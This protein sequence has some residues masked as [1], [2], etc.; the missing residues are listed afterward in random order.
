MNVKQ[1]LIYTLSGSLALILSTNTSA[2]SF[3]I[4]EQSPAYLG[5]AF[6]G[7]A[8]YVSDASSIFFN[9]AAIGELE[10]SHLTVAGN[11]IFTRAKFN[12]QNSNTNGAPGKTDE[13]G[14]VPNLYWTYPVAERLTFG[15]GVNAP[16]GLSSKYRDDWAGRYLATYSN[17]ELINVNAVAALDLGD[18]W[19]L[20][21]GLNYQRLDVTLESRVDSTLGI[22]PQPATDSSARIKGDDDDLVADLSLYFKPSS[23]TRLG[24]VWR[25]GGEFDL[26]GDA[27]F[28]LNALCSPGAG[29]PTGVPPAPTTGT[30]CAAMLNARAGDAKTSIA[31]PDTLTFSISQALSERWWLHV[32]VARTEWSSLQSVNIINTGNNLTISELELKYKDTIRYAVGLSYH[33]GFAWTWRFGVAA[34]EAPQTNPELLNPRIPDQD[35][36]WFSTGFNYELSKNVSIDVGYAYIKVDKSRIENTE[37]QTGHYVEG[38]FDASVNILGVQGNWRF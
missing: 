16:F 17:L 13:T 23:Y 6:S 9:P 30:I 26:S 21:I 22:N 12:D 36:I 35:R 2:T 24:L 33:P 31:L 28:S 29:Y 18:Y 8:S 15:L 38:E 5:Q 19:A 25:Q 27:K 32:D 37:L 1:P 10:G 14:F 7:T 3:Q 20:G 34:D 4:L 11:A